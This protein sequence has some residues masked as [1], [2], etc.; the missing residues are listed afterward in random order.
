MRRKLR[1]FYQNNKEKIWK[2]LGLTILIYIIIQIVN[3]NIK[4]DREEN[5][6]AN[7][8]LEEAIEQN[9][10]YL[11]SSKPT[12]TDSDV[13][14]EVVQSDTELIEKFIT[15]S[16][17]GKVEE[18]YQLLSK[19][20]KE[21]LFPTVQDFYNNYYKDIFNEKKSYDVEVLANYGV[22]TYKIKLLP[23]IMASGKVSD[24]Y[25]EDYYTVITEEKEKKLNIHNFIRKRE[26]EK[27][28][29]EQN[30]EIEVFNRFVYYDD[31]QYEISFKNTGTQTIV[32]DSKEATNTVYLKDNNGVK[33]SWFGNEISNNQL[34]L[35][36]GE[37]RTLR[38]K[39]NK[40]YNPNRKEKSI[41]FT[42][43]KIDGIEEKIEIEV[44][45]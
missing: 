44:Q 28:T 6:N 45:I 40:V 20:C 31:E 16:N 42:D 14:E 15:N 5:A 30:L 7:E 18:A 13:S 9:S 1:L 23:D 21:E 43:I 35:E 22:V 8:I 25:I 17:E 38:I 3:Y 41:S 4:K 19:D 32:L 36:A 26:V 11:P 34:I 27:T 39:F 37:T 2:V 10:T 24:E 12:I 33:Y 29:K